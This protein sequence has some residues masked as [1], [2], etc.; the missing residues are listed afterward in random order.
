MMRNADERQH[1][2]LT[3]HEKSVREQ[4]VDRPP[5]KQD[6]SFRLHGALEVFVQL[7]Q[8]QRAIEN[9]TRRFGPLCWG[10]AYC[11][12][13]SRP[14]R[15]R[16]HRRGG[17]R[18]WS[19]GTDRIAWSMPLAEFSREQQRFVYVFKL[20]VAVTS[21]RDQV[22][23]LLKE[24]V[25]L[26]SDIRVRFGQRDMGDALDRLA[27]QPHRDAEERARALSWLDQARSGLSLEAVVCEAGDIVAALLNAKNPGIKVTFDLDKGFRE[28][29]KFESLLQV[30]YFLLAR[31]LPSYRFCANCGQL[32]FQGR[33][34]KNTCGQRC[35]TLLGKRAWAR[36][37]RE[38]QRRARAASHANRQGKVL[39]GKTRNGSAAG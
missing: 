31:S 23:D 20:G 36:R 10:N 26:I 38:N 33:P 13:V 39:S 6:L 22:P 5:L 35:A 2:L 34:D 9:F 7:H 18:R 29:P 8:T 17:V 24:A 19:G 21:Q 32:Y 37:H 27:G 4:T 15:P 25:D 11:R 1:E 30:L 3:L 14:A 12:L 28:E 16:G